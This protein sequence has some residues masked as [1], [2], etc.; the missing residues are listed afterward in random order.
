MK[1][2]IKTFVMT[3]LIFLLSNHTAYANDNILEIESN[4]PQGATVNRN[5][6]IINISTKALID[7]DRPVGGTSIR[8]Y[9]STASAMQP[10]I[11]SRK[12]YPG[13]GCSTAINGVLTLDEAIDLPED[14]KIVSFSV[15]G[16]DSS[17]AGKVNAY[18]SSVPSGGNYYNIITDSTG[19]NANQPGRFN[20]GGFLDHT[21]NSDNEGL[22]VRLNLSAETGIEVCGFRI[23]YVP[24]DV[25]SDV[26]FVNNFYR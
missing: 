2:F 7:E 11:M 3:T 6:E 10:H 24:P 23:G 13:G 21:V 20:I 14:T 17:N 8:Y 4:I 18:L 25:A 9:S 16:N 19:T 5:G 1:I 12:N 22:L 26:I 15:L